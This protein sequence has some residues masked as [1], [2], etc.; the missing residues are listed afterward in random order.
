LYVVDVT[1]KVVHKPAEEGEECGPPAGAEVGYVPDP[2]VL[3]AQGYSLCPECFEVE[4]LHVAGEVAEAVEEPVVEG[5][6]EVE[7]PGEEGEPE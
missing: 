1:G 3:V 6:E 4:A 2:N 5:A 7:G